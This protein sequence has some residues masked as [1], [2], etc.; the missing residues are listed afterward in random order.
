MLSVFMVCPFLI[1][2]SVFSNVI[3]LNQFGS[4]P[5]EADRNLEIIQSSRQTVHIVYNIRHLC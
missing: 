5:V 1:V 2:P 3:E 4:I